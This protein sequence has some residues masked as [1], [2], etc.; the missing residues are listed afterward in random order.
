VPIPEGGIGIGDPGVLFPLALKTADQ[1]QNRGIAA[2]ALFYVHLYNLHQP[3]LLRPGVQFDGRGLHWLR[4]LYEHNAHYFDQ[5]LLM[6]LKGLEERGLL[7][8]S[9]VIVTADHG[10]EFFDLGGL[11]HGWHINP[12]VMHVPLFV[13]YPHDQTNAPMPGTI[14]QRVVNLI[15]LA[16]T[17]CEAMGASICRESPLQGVSLLSAN[18]PSNRTFPLLNW[19]SPIAGELGFSP[20]RMRVLNCE[21]GSMDVFEPG[22]EGWRLQTRSSDPLKFARGLGGELDELFRFWQPGRTNERNRMTLTGR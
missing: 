9:L 14:S 5:Q 8:A 22:A 16:P 17:I 7:E 20:A 3:L 18:G 1:H 4:A 12:P 6:F 15:D 11:Y 13:H 2:P 10:E 21:S 19:C